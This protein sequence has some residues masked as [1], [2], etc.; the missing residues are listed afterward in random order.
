MKRQSYILLILILTTNLAFG[1]NLNDQIIT[2]YSD[3][4]YCKITLINDQNIFYTYQKKKTE[5]YA[6]ISLQEIISYNWKSKEIKLQ[7]QYGEKLIPYSPTNKWRIGLD[8]VQQINYPISHSILILN[9][10]KRNH[11]IYMGPNYTRLFNNYFGDELI[12]NYDKNSIG[13]NFG[14]RYI[15]DSKWEKTNFFLQ[16]DF[17]IYKVKYLE[18]QGHFIG[19][20]DKEKVIIENNGSI[21]INYK[22]SN[23]IEIFGGIG[24]GSPAGFFLMIE[25]FLPHSF[26]GIEYRFE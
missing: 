19:T 1:Q 2:N 25:D 12:N 11:N 13:I 7:N 16:L 20:K 18:Y 9:L 4:I 6:N 8:Y 15:V 3:T 17:S 23:R 24:I 22:M 14:Y 10:N 5:K 26:I 21:G